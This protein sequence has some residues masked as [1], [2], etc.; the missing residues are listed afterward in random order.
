MWFLL[1]CLSGTSDLNDGLWG[2]R[3]STCQQRKT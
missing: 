2:E 1:A 3:L